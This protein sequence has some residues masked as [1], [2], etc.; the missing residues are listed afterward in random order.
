MSAVKLDKRSAARETNGSRTEAWSQ[1]QVWHAGGPAPKP[2]CVQSAHLAHT[3]L[4]T[5]AMAFEVGQDMYEVLHGDGA[6]RLG[7]SLR[8]QM[9][10][11]QVSMLRA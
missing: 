5:L 9:I 1:W 2:F 8:R 7:R 6:L 10:T 11:N 4:D 3:S